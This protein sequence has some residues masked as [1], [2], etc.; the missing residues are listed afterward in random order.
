MQLLKSTAIISRIVGI[1]VATTLLI[2]FTVPAFSQQL[3]VNENSQEMKVKY[4]EGDNDAM[5]FNLRYNN[6]SGNG[7]K[8]MVLNE[9]GEV[10][11]QNNY[12]GKKFKKR[13]RLTRLTDTDGVTFIIR[14]PKENVQLSYKVRV[15]SKVVDESSVATD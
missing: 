2:L 3:A 10:L 12:S 6:D 11:F 4:I 1:P 5:L 8:L 15:T 14:S 7:F 13:I 9:T